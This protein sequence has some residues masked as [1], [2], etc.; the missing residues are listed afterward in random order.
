VDEHYYMNPDWFK[1]NASGYDSYERKGPRAFVGEYAAH[2]GDRANNFGSALAE[3]VYM[4]GL[5]RNSDV[6]AM[7]SYAPLFSKACPYK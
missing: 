3:A 6:V 2:N 7:A 4:I 5:E 1:T